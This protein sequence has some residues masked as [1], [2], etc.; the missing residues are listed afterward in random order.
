VRRRLVRG[1]DR[2]KLGGRFGQLEIRLE[3]HRHGGGKGMHP[4]PARRSARA[5][6]EL[7]PV[8]S[9]FGKSLGFSAWNTNLSGKT[10]PS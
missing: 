7:A 3:I 2:F 9:T 8:E 6:E 4:P 10:R 5:T 1:Q